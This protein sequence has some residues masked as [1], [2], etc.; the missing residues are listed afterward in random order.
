MKRISSIF[1]CFSGCRGARRIMGT[2]E[3]AERAELIEN[4]MYGRMTPEA[5]EAEAVRLCLG[6]FARTGNPARFDPMKEASWTL[7]MAVAWIAWRSTDFVR[8]FWDADRHKCWRWHFREWR[9]E[10]AGPKYAGHF[11]EQQISAT[12][13]LV[14]LG[15]RHYRT[16]LLLPERSISIQDSKL[17]LWRALEE[18]IIQ[19]TAID[20]ATGQRITIADHHWRDLEVIEERG[21]DVLRPRHLWNDPKT[22]YSDV[23]IRRKALLS[24]WPPPRLEHPSDRGLPLVRPEGA[25]YMPLCCAAYWIGTKGGT[26]TFDPH[27][28]PIWDNAFS[29]LLARISSEEVVVTGARDGEREKIPGHVFAATVFA[30]PSAMTR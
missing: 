14:G 17:Q 24:I 18:K 19:A 21:R 4:V 6:K 26:V 30:T 22:G 15:E 16:H 28:A 2:I 12:L 27:D 23:A 5:A 20:I 10:P 25:G 7:P 9:A 29:P 1:I 11:L 13:S 8:R 3:R